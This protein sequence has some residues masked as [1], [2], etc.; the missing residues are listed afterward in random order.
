MRRVNKVTLLGNPMHIFQVFVSSEVVTGRQ[1]VAAYIGAIA[2]PLRRKR[3]GL[4][5]RTWGTC[6]DA[7]NVLKRACTRASGLHVGD[8]CSHFCPKSSTGARTGA[9]SQLLRRR[10]AGLRGRTW[11]HVQRHTP[12]VLKGACTRLRG[13]TLGTRAVASKNNF[14]GHVQ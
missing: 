9:I 8:T 6:N 11:G 3:A 5:G 7:P 2:R 13:C 12:N 14:D 4:W 10:R 1:N